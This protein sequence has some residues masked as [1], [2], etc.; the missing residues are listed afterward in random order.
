MSFLLKTASQTTLIWIEYQIPSKSSS[1]CFGL[2]TWKLK[3]QEVSLKRPAKTDLTLVT[4]CC[5][6]SKKAQV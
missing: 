1:H 4:I 6:S 5:P 3:C 2:S